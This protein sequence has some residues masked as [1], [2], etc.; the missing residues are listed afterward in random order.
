[1]GEKKAQKTTAFMQPIDIYIYTGINSRIKRIS[2]LC[3]ITFAVISTAL[4][5]RTELICF[6]FKLPSQ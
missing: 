5:C 1:M 4:K 3:K 2:I 6:L